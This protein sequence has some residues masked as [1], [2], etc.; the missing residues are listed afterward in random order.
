MRLDGIRAGDDPV[1]YLLGSEA[2]E[3]SGAASELLMGTSESVTYASS[4]ENDD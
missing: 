2:C 4:I 3:R 1:K